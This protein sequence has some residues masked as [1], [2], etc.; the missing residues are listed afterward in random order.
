M[1]LTLNDLKSITLGAAKVTEENGRIKINRF[2]EEEVLFYIDRDA[3]MGRTFSQRCSAA[4]GI[5]LNFKTDSKRLK[6]AAEVSTGGS[7]TY[8]SFDIYENGEP[9]GY[10]SNFRDEELELDYTVQKFPYGKFEGEF[11]LSEDSSH[12]E[13]YFP[14]SVTVDD[15]TVE[16]DDGAKIEPIKPMRKL[17]VYGDSITQGY[18]AARSAKRYAARLANFLGAEE[19]NKAIGG[20]IFVPGLVEKK[21]P[22]EPDFITVAYGTNDWNSTDGKN[23]YEDAR[24][25]YKRLSLHYPTAKIFAITP[26]W[27]LNYGE[28]KPLGDFFTVERIIR[29]V[30]AELKNVTVISGFD[31]VGHD[32]ML[33]ADLRLHPR[34][35][36][37]DEYFEN[38]AKKI[39]EENDK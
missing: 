30:T 18:D 1:R 27:R 38:L 39:G 24:E 14:W 29:E 8:F 4:A 26:I 32:K 35:V 13:V 3:K 19:F 20:E 11:I 12:I 9:I 7:R 25:F 5:K 28:E 16:L 36:G 34:D 23:F 17:L 2:T 10:L 33:F 31:F 21:L 6:L 22:F 37:F 15:I